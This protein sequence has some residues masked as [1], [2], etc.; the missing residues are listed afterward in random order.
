MNMIENVAEAIY[1]KRCI[2]N[3]IPFEDLFDRTKAAYLDEAHTAIKAMRNLFKTLSG[4][5][6]NKEDNDRWNA[7]IDAA[8]K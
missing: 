1:N 8:L 2:N 3:T 6:G 4:P 7:A 5:I